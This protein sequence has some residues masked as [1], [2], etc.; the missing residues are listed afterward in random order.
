VPALPNDRTA[1]SGVTFSVPTTAEAGPLVGDLSPGDYRGV[2]VRRT[3]AANT[4]PTAEDVSGL[5]WSATPG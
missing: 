2:W 1:P 3:I 4:P 5:A